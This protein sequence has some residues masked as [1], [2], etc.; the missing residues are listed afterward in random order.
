[1]NETQLLQLESKI[2][3][4]SDGYMSDV[5]RQAYIRLLEDPEYYTKLGVGQG[6]HSGLVTLGTSYYYRYNGEWKNYTDEQRKEKLGDWNMKLAVPLSHKE[7]DDVWKWIVEKHRRTRDEQHEKLREDRRREQSARKLDKSHTFSTYP[8]NIRKSLEGNLWTEIGKYPVKWIV[9]DP[10]MSVIYKAHQYDYETSVTDSGT[11][12]QKQRIYKL[13]IDD[14]KIRCIPIKI[15][16][17]ESQLDFLQSQS[18]TTYTM[19][20]ENTT[21]KS[22]LKLE[23]PSIRLWTI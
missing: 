21:G 12:E 23:K 7:F 11:E 14:I 4:L 8:E 2:H 20:F 16:K 19:T 17:H 10:K 18:Q 15:M 1:M 9:A 13:S 5:D 3:S 22:L 6:R